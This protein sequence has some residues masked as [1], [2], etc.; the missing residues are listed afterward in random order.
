MTPGTQKRGKAAKSALE[1]CCKSSALSVRERETAIA[2][3]DN[4]IVAAMVSDCKVMPS[5]SVAATAANSGKKG[6]KK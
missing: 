4:Q 6:G 1:L 2:V 5:G 3:K